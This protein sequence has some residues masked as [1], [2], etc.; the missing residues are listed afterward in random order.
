MPLVPSQDREAIPLLRRIAD[1]LDEATRQARPRR[2][3]DPAGGHTYLLRGER[4]ASGAATFTALAGNLPTI[5]LRQPAIFAGEQR[6]LLTV[7]DQVIVS[8]PA[9]Q[10]V[11]AQIH[12]DGLIPPPFALGNNVRAITDLRHH[13]TAAEVEPV[14]ELFTWDTNVPQI[15]SLFDV[16]L[17][18]NTPLVIPL[19]VVLTS[20]SIGGTMIDALLVQGQ[21]A[22]GTLRVAFRFFELPYEE[23]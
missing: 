2:F 15:P 11:T 18:A 9:A 23:R 13:T 10:R 1:A 16:D 17:A 12:L 21:T 14:A 19:R 22:A 8:S 5:L 4:V 7:V 3:V 20:L 6:K